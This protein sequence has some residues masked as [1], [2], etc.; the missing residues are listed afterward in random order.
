M[1]ITVKWYNEEQQAIIHHFEGAWDWDDLRDSLKAMGE[2][3]DGRRMPALIDVS[4]TKILPDGNVLLHGKN[5][6]AY[7]PDNITDMVFLINSQ[8]LKTFVS[9]VFGIVPT[10]R[11]RT[12]FAKNIE[13][14]R[15]V[16]DKII[17]DQAATVR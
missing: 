11:S 2:L 16:I 17:A 5:N 14:G 7:I 4:N 1:P 10:W 12:Q 3:A 8:L 13:E 15:K 6:L 9:M